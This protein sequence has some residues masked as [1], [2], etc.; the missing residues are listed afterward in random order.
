[1]WRAGELAAKKASVWPGL[2]VPDPHTARATPRHPKRNAADTS[3][4]LSSDGLDAMFLPKKRVP[5]Y[6]PVQIPLSELDLNRCSCRC[7][8]LPA[9]ADDR[10]RFHVVTLFMSLPNVN[11]VTAPNLA[12]TTPAGLLQ[13][14]LDIVNASGPRPSA[15]GVR[16]GCPRAQ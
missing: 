13:E 3:A 14:I 1:M 15:V 16:C 9:Q 12:I 6:L 10:R 4:D 8:P 7:F 5:D 11:I 2:S